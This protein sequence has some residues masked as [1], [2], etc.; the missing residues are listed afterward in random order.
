M[1]DHFQQVKTKKTI[2]LFKD[3]L[4]GKIII[5]FC[6]LRAKVYAY[7]MDDDSGKKKKKLKEQKSV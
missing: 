6:V 3:K 2:S 7:L 5:E 1:K 4:A